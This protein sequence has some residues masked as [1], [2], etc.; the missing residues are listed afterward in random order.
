MLS[1]GVRLGRPNL[2]RP[3][4]DRAGTVSVTSESDEHAPG[5]GRLA[6]AWIMI[7]PIM[8]ES[9]ATRHRVGDSATHH[10][11]I[12][13]VIRVMALNGDWHD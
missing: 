8:N 13:P 7:E 5:P 4:A 12:H 9:L 6:A 11:L 10:V 1:A 3:F 2:K